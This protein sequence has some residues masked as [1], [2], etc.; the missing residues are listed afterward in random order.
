[1]TDPA[2]E[3][4]QYIKGVGEGFAKKLKGL[5]LNT[6][7]DV[8]YNFPREY[9]DRRNLKKLNNLKPDTTIICAAIVSAIKVEKKAKLNIMKA[10]LSDETGEVRGI[11]FNQLYLKKVLKE[12]KAYIFKG[13]TVW[14]KFEQTMELHIAETEW[15]T[16]QQSPKGNHKILPVYMLKAGIYQQQV[17]QISTKIIEEKLPMF[18]DPLPAT[19]KQKQKLLLLVG[20]VH[21]ATSCSARPRLGCLLILC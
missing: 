6:I 4:L 10:T 18:T 19:L 7:K 2:Q 1:M 13:K 14:N 3:K 17:R 9:E 21:L 8:L 20:V 5:G 12:G 16:L 11:W 15:Q